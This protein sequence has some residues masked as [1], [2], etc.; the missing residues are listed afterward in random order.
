VPSLY[1]K[2]AARGVVQAM[3]AY[4]KPE[5]VNLGCGHEITIS[6]LARKIA[7]LSGFRGDLRWD[8]T[9]PN[10]QPRRCLDVTRAR[11]EFGF[12]AGTTL[13]TGLQETLDWYLIHRSANVPNSVTSIGSCRSRVSVPGGSSGAV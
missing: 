10:G 1:V 2:D 3:L 9:K 5:P 13:E 4:D 6:D 8:R 12:T 11:E 7:D